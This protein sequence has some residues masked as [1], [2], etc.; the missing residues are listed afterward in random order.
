MRTNFYIDAF[1]LYYGCLRDSPHK[2]LNVAEF[3]RQSFP[4]PRNDLNRVRYFTAIVKARP[5]DPQQP[6]R[7]QTFLRAL[8]TL[9]DLTIHLGQYFDSK[10]RAKLV[11]P[12]AD[13]TDKVM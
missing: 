9:P 8:R 5:Y 10:V 7:Q 12:L 3:C 13:G 1:N 6:V 2:W 4:P 11:T